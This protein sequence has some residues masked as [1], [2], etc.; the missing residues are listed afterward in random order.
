[1]VAAGCASPAEAPATPPVTGP[2]A[3]TR[4][5]GGLLYVSDFYASEILIYPA[6]QKNPDPTGSITD[7]VSYPYNLAVDAAG[8]LYVQNNNNTVTEYAKGTTTPSK[9]LDEPESGVGTGIC[10]TV[11]SDGTV[12]TVDHYAGKV[13]EFKN[14]STSPTTTLDL[15]EAFGVALDSKNDLYVG[16][17]PNSSGGP[18]HVNRYKPGSTKGHD[19]GI[20]VEYS[21]GLAVDDDDN[22][23]VG[24]QGN[25]VVDIFKPGTDTP[26]RTIST[27]PA[28][29]YQFAFDKNDK[30]LYLVSGSPAEV[31]VYDYKSGKLKWTDTEG[32]NGSEGYAEGVALSPA[33]PQ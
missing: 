20:T 33:Q 11:G 26:F 28:A 12:Y 22:L 2:M 27:S 1:M 18:G 16:W 3:A 5:G 17:A 9:T 32:M 15:S 25:R 4:S 14:G 31:Y 21:G 10:I 29:P 7:G 6:A 13:Y 24:D 8:T 19:L 30:E 23:L